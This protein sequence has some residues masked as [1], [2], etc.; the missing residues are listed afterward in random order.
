MGEA[1]P[2]E[3]EWTIMEVL[4]KSGE[5]MTASEIIEKLK[6]IKDVSP[7][8]IR[9]LI[10]RLLQKGII[11]YTVDA[12]DSRVY[13]Y[14]AIRNREECLQEKSKRFVNS[15]F[16]GNSFGMVASL[17]KNEQ[18]SDEQIEELMEMLKSGKK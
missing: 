16:E 11:D 10:N 17:V 8:T 14:R 12:R 1:M 2:S 7:K 18:F 15:Y 5:S 9:V 3:N 6:G 13:H 4:W